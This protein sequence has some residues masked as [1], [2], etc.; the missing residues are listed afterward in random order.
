[1]QENTTNSKF[2]RKTLL[3]FSLVLLAMMSKLNA[4]QANSIRTGVTFQWATTQANSNSAAELTTI[5]INSI[6]YDYLIVPTGYELTQL[7]TD[8]HNANNIWENGTKIVGS[9]AVATWDADAL[10]AF[11]SFNLNYYF[12]A[13]GN[14]QAFCGNTNNITN[15]T[16]TAQ[17]QS[18]LY[19]PGV[20]S[21]EGAVIAITE[22]N[23]NNCFYIELYGTPANG[24]PD[25]ILGGTFVRANASGRWTSVPGPPAANVDYWD[26]GRLNNGGG[27]I[28]IALF[29]LSE[30]APLNSVIKKVTLTAAA[31]DHGDGKFF[32]ASRRSQLKVFKS[33]D[34]Q[35]AFVGDTATYTIVATN[36]AGPGIYVDSS[37][38]VTDNFPTGLQFVSANPS[39]GTFDDNTGIWDIGSLSPGD[40]ETVIVK[41]IILPQG[42]YANSV[43]IQGA[44]YDPDSVNNFSSAVI[45]VVVTD[46]DVN[47][48]N[49]GESI[50]GS[51]S[52][53]DDIPSGLN[54]TYN[55]NVSPNA[56]N[57]ATDVP[58]IA[59]DGSY[60]FSG[61]VPG[62]YTFD[63]EVCAVGQTTNCPTEVLVITVVDPESDQNQPISNIDQAS[64]EYGSTTGVNIDI[65]ANDAPGNPDGSLGIPTLGNLSPE[66]GTVTIDPLT[67]I[68][69][70]I[71]N[72]GF[73]GTDTFSYVICDESITPVAICDTS[74][75]IV[76][77]MGEGTNGLTS[78]DDFNSTF[79]GVSVTANALSNDI[80]PN[81]DQLTVTAVT[82]PTAITGGTYTIDASGQYTF[83]PDPGFTGSTNFVYTVCD[84]LGL[85]E[86]ATVY[87]NVA[88]EPETDPDF[89]AGAV[90]V[91]LTGDL[92]TNDEAYIGSTYNTVAPIPSASNPSS[93]LPVIA[94]DGTYT[95]SSTT[96]G[97]YEFT[98]MVCPPDETTGC[99]AEILQI[100]IVD[101][102]LTTN[103]PIANVD[104]SVTMEG[105][106]VQ[107]DITSNDA[108]GN[109]LGSLGAPTI[110]AGPSNGTASID[111]ATG[112][113]VYTPNSGFVGFDTVTYQV[114][115]TL[116]MPALCETAIAIIEVLPTGTNGLTASDDF[117]TLNT[118][119]VALGNVLDNDTD[120]NA[121][122]VLT[123]TASSGSVT[124]G[125]YTI[126]ASGNYTFI[127]TPGFEGTASFTYEVCDNNGDCE[128]ATVYII[129]HD[130]V[131][132]LGL[133]IIESSISDENCQVRLNW[134]FNNLEGVSNIELQRSMDNSPFESIADLKF[135]ADFDEEQ[136]IEYIDDNVS[137]ANISYRM[138]LVSEEGAS[139]YSSV[140][141]TTITCE[142]E[143]MNIYPNPAND[144]INIYVSGL[145]ENSYQAK[146]YNTTGQ[147]INLQSLSVR[148]ESI[149]TRM[150]ISNLT[151]GMYILVIT[152][153]DQKVIR[154]ELLS[155]IH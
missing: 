143:E 116:T 73:V 35:N 145:I 110:S 72:P 105:Q 27:T 13:G 118:G 101:P 11:Q 134:L 135:Q 82:S 7:G 64:V 16:T 8:G 99:V 9:S 30:V 62:T 130:E 113:L 6:D 67:G 128:E 104:Q 136:N 96:P 5:T 111:P 60:T 56:N 88:E 89:N 133:N 44:L 97:T 42:S 85:C 4:Q 54:V 149:N 52:T 154:R 131:Q 12:E 26:G 117:Q 141:N 153:N 78:S 41:A 22:R 33:S 129:I 31:S 63:V 119:S 34:V 84:S 80:D 24:G 43:S 108:A 81:G 37:V 40:T 58:V 152:N 21:T 125:M 98:V 83:T 92:S 122:D 115:D 139:A 70:Y 123:V 51:V 55:N 100:T 50:T 109:N 138:K 49:V 103:E 107:F 29:Y 59:M 144:V 46:P 45:D 61:S 66:N 94:A 53:N 32:I 102:M 147:L 77:V 114:C 132:K 95:F 3:F 20:V 151:D 17:K 38:S 91:S 140:L 74:I 112:E 93:D 10:A 142:R 71:P 87:I 48:G 155:V 76:D 79:Q 57:P 39:V 124:G 148:N 75:V 47:S 137:S 120:P 121:G 23:A 86:Q 69:N 65:S 36:D 146:I 18:L 15:A 19:S 28:G 90:G 126:D 2:M 1:M 14:G 106:P 25:Q 127:P 150:D 68:A